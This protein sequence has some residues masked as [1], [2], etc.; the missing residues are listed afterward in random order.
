MKNLRL[1]E[2]LKINVKKCNSLKVIMNDNEDMVLGNEEID[3]VDS[4]TTL[5]SIISKDGGFGE[6]VKSRIVRLRGA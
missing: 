1:Q 5:S 6:D 2:G 4:F 3:Q